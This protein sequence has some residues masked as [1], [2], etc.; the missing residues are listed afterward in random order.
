MI[1]KV[2]VV[3]KCVMVGG[4]DRQHVEAEVAVVAAIVA[5]V[6]VEKPV[7][8][9][10]VE[11]KSVAFEVH[12]TARVVNWATRNELLSQKVPICN[13][14]VLVTVKVVYIF[15]AKSP[16]Q[17]VGHLGRVCAAGVDAPIHV[18]GHTQIIHQTCHCIAF[19]GGAVVVGILVAYETGVDHLARQ[20]VG[21]GVIGRLPAVQGVLQRVGAFV[22]GQ[23]LF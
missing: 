10:S 18:C 7:G 11:H 22:I 8:V 3:G 4:L 5:P 16:F 21:N 19:V 13:R 1:A 14:I 15:Q 17:R 6:D 20:Y 2:A 23:N 9:K 12:G